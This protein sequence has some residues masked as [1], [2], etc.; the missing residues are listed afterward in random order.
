MAATDNSCFFLPSSSPPFFFSF[1][2]QSTF[3][4]FSQWRQNLIVRLSC[5]PS[6]KQSYG[7]FEEMK[8]GHGVMK[9][10]HD[11]A[12]FYFSLDKMAATDNSC[13]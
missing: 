5:R 1:Y 6:T 3:F 9:K 7:A 13:F 8:K 10:G 12:P 4:L 2:R 11:A